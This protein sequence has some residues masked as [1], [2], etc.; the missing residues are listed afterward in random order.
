MGTFTIRA[1]D[2]DEN[3]AQ[4]TVAVMHGV[5]RGEALAR[6]CEAIADGFID[7]RVEGP[8]G[9][10]WTLIDPAAA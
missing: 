10:T 3:F 7:V 6:G 1:V 9:Q 2:P 5:T 8:M 4:G